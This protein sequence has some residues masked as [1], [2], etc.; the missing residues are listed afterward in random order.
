VIALVAGAAAIATAPQRFFPGSD[1][2]QIITYFD[3][4]ADVTTNATRD[5]IEAMLPTLNDERFDWL[6]DHVAYVGFGGP[7]FVFSAQAD[8]GTPD[9]P[10][11]PLQRVQVVKG[12]YEDGELHEQVLDVAG[13]ANGASVDTATCE[14]SG[15]GHEQL[16]AVWEDENFNPDATAFYYA[17]VLENPSCRWSQQICIA[18]QVD[19]VNP[20][21][22]PDGLKDCCSDEH[23]KTVQ[24]RAWSSPIWY[25]PQG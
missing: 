23:R 2:A 25:S 1:R 12:W 24:E 7:R 13:G 18:E 3:L 16:C 10:G 11:T 8:A 6:V 19:C 17:R 9:Y 14:Q 21:S 4:P 20:E 22:L 5:E 15:A